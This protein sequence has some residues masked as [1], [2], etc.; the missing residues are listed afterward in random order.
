[1]KNHSKPFKRRN[2]LKVTA[3][4]SLAILD[5]KTLLSAPTEKANAPS[6]RV[7]EQGSDKL[8]VY[9]D[10][11]GFTHSEF[12]RIRVRSKASK[13]EWQSSFP[14]ITRSLF[15][16]AKIAKT[17]GSTNSMEHYFDHLKDWSHTYTN[18][19]TNSPIEVEV[20]KADGSPIKKA[21]VHPIAKAGA[22]TIRD[23]KAYFVMAKPALVAVDIDGQM[24][25]Q[26][27]GYGYTGP[28]IHTVSIY[29]NPI[30]EKPDMTDPGVLVIKAGTKPPT[31]PTAY[32]TL[33][34]SPGVHDI[35]R[36]F[37]IHED[38]QYYI[39]GDAVVYGALNNGGESSGRNIKIFGYGT[40]SGDRITHPKYDPEF[41]KV[42]KE[43]NAE[44]T[45][46][47][48]KQWKGIYVE[49][50]ENAVVEGICVANPANHSINM[51]GR[52]KYNGKKLTFARWVKITTWR[53][54]GDGIGS[55]DEIEDCFIRTQD[56]CSYVK[57]DRRRCVFWTD[58][59]GAIFHMA[60]I[61]KDKPILIEDCDVIYSRGRSKGWEG[62]RVFSQR[63]EGD[64]GLQKVNVLIR[65]FRIE[66]KRPT[67]NLINLY[68]SDDFRSKKPH[69]GSSYSG[70]TFQ[71]ITAAGKSVCGLP[72]V[73]HGCKEAPWSGITFDNVVIAGKK[74]TSLKDFGQVNEFVTDI[75]F[76]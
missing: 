70:I 3:V 33:Y 66:D 25:D 1:M 42:E 27:T 73:L 50:A 34:F 47:V 72:E 6:T 59:N 10:V 71:N 76:K 8:I 74:L 37:K 49:S 40:L 15:S 56:D 51:M 35:G 7:F 14:L 38:R 19:E 69:E 41:L 18:V 64:V 21:A 62:G 67:L 22:V 43:G 30:M 48:S 45:K 16:Q 4:A 60:S 5:A 52:G 9:S 20:S 54:N 17:E 57:G 44:Q 13:S 29:A 36:N 61:P 63:G 11:P 31:D 75:T 55:C 26:D 23:G 2:F 65:N 39:P 68:S 12:Y 32:K 24:D 58:A 46:I 53:A 28:P